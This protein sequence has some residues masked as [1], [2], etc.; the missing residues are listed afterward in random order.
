MR[1]LGTSTMSVSLSATV[2]VRDASGNLVPSPPAPSPTWHE[3]MRYFRMSQTTDDLFDAFRNIYLSLESVLSHIAPV[4][5]HPNG[6]LD[7][8][9]GQWLKRALN[10][11]AQTVDVKQFLKNP[12][13]AVSDGVDEVYQELYV[14]VRTAIF[15][16][17]NGRPV[18]LPQDLS[19]RFRVADAKERYTRLYLALAEQAFTTRFMSGGL[20][21]YAARRMGM[22]AAQITNLAVTSDDTGIQQGDDLSTMSPK[23]EVVHAFAATHAPDLDEPFVTFHRGVASKADLAGLHSV[24]RF[25]S[26]H[27]ETGE[28]LQVERL[29]GHLSLAEFDRVE[30]VV[31]VRIARGNAPRSRY[32]T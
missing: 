14:D 3:S 20:S 31:G 32:A 19:Q 5:L 26:V 25:G 16:A 22:A 17:K 23:G 10:V 13:A 27:K 24:V 8:R 1:L 21:P 7:E 12:G 9:E 2:E 6:R 18:L 28:P 30:V 11:A 4:R 29:P 15:H